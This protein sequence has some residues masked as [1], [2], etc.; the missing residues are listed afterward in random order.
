MMAIPLWYSAFCGVACAYFGFW[1][2]R[3]R[4]WGIIQTEEDVDRGKRELALGEKMNGNSHVNM[5]CLGSPSGGKVECY[6]EE[7]RLGA[8]II[9]TEARLISPVSGRIRKISPRGNAFWILTDGGR[10]IEVR[11]CSSDDDLLD[12]YFRPRVVQGEVVKKG[13][14]LLEYDRE[15]LC[16]KC[17]DSAVYLTTGRGEESVELTGKEE[18]KAGESLIWLA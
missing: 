13:K 10:E 17:A 6:I 16:R 3:S 9:T 12:R 7:E 1:F 14:L 4:N 11:A 2:G 8:R 15:N 18:V 5:Q